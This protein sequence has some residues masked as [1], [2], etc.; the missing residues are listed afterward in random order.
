MVEQLTLNQRVVG[1]IPTRRT[2]LSE[3][4]RV[5]CSD[6]IKYGGRINSISDGEKQVL[7][8]AAAGDTS[9]AKTLIERYLKLLFGFS[10]SFAPFSRDQAFNVTVTA[11]ARTLQR[12]PHIERD[13]EWMV[14]LFREGLAECMRT[15]PAGSAN[16]KNG[17]LQIIHE[18]L[19]RLSP[20]D[21]AML[22]LRDQCHFPF[23]T[24]AAIFGTSASE[25]RSACLVARERLRGALKDI[26]NKTSEAGHGL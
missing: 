16:L 20:S 26:L 23:E 3:Q 5:A 8:R 12:H 6:K 4:D 19:I 2:I 1:S 10:S 17:Q 25:S 21:K 11:F 18:A 14:A 22:L 13:G 7:E 9:A 15:A 24:I